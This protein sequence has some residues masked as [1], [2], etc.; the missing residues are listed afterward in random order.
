MLFDLPLVPGLSYRDELIDVAEEARLIAEIARLHLAPFQFQGWT[1]KRLT[2]SFGWSYDFTERSFAPAEPLPD[3]LVPLRD[4]A[5]LFSGISPAEF[6]HALV[7]RYDPGAAIGWHRD[8]PQFGAV[9]G[10][11]LAAPAV[12]RFRRRTPDGFARAQLQ[13]HPRSAYLLSGEARDAWEHG[14][15]PHDQLRFSVTF[16]TLSPRGRAAATARP[17]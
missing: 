5:A 11:S 7:T 16:R 6:V 15:A 1:G 2:R 3:F 8:R 13:L 10:I 14:I 12:L 4:K 9:V 17:A